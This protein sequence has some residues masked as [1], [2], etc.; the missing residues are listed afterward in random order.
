MTTVYIDGGC[1]HNNQKDAT[2]REMIFVVLSEDEIVLVEGYA[3][4]GSNNIAELLAVR[5][6][7]AWAKTNGIT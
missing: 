6:A 7:L 2:K 1:T 5:A 3:S 4:G